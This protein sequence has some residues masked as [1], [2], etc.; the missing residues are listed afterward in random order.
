MNHT[1]WQQ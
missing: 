1:R